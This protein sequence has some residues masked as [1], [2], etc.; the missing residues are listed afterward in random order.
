MVFGDELLRRAR[1]FPI[2]LLLLGT[3]TFLALRRARGRQ[4][5]A[6]WVGGAVLVLGLADGGMRLLLVIFGHREA[7]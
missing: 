3:L 2:V 4:A 5:F 7:A 6:L 1:P